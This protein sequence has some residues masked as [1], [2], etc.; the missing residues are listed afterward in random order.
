M[1]QVMGFAQSW[2]NLVMLC[3]MTVDYMVC[4]NGYE[5]GPIVLGRGL[6]QGDPISPYIFIVC[7]EGLS[8]IL[9]E[10]EV[11][12]LIHCCKVARN[13]IRQVPLGSVSRPDKWYWLWDKKGVYSVKSGYRFLTSDLAVD[14]SRQLPTVWKSIWKL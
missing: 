13:L 5:V 8:S 11:R 6:R 10:Y 12:G 1:M 2:I 14:S 9:R 3:V 4:Q 7:A